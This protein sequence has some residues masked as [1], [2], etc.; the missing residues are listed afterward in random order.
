MR[1][2]IICILLLGAILLVSCN[3]KPNERYEVQYN[4]KTV[5]ID[6]LAQ[7]ISCEDYQYKYQVVRSAIETATTITYPNNAEFW[8]KEEE[9]HAGGGW[10]D[11]YDP[12]KYI[13]GEDLVSMIPKPK[14]S[15]SSKNYLIIII[16]LAGGIWNMVSP[17]SSWY[18][19]YGWRYKNAEPSDE[20]LIITRVGGI[21]AVIIAVIFL[22][23]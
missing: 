18:L 12:I 1:K 17:K 14:S 10:S 23:V 8:W 3:S 19:S 11:N 22:F 13:P 6:T 20:A 7:T 9:N 4:G 5:I 21:L 16:L 2:W 15:G